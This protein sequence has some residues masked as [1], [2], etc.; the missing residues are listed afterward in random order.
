MAKRRTSPEQ[1]PEL[2]GVTPDRFTRLYR[3]VQI[4]AA[5]PQP[6]TALARRLG[7]DVRGFYRDLELLR[8]AGVPITLAKGRY[9]L[10]G[11]A[12]DALARLPFPDPHL[13]LGDALLLARG[14]S[15]VHQKLK[16]HISRAVP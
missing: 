4:L 16:A 6:R 3:L 13:T 2:P 12:D 10:E 14:R 8:A 11:K 9:C 15:A 1:S 7:L 5:G